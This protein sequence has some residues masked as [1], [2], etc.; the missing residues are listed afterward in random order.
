MDGWMDDLKLFASSPPPVIKLPNRGNFID[1][2]SRR[3]FATAISFIERERITL[4]IIIFFFFV[5][6]NDFDQWFL[7]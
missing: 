1:Q 6:A 3:K 5:E 4:E 7:S 2:L